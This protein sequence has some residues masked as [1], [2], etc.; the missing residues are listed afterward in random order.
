M[1]E[2]ESCGTWVTKHNFS[3]NL[4][5]GSLTTIQA[6]AAELAE[7]M[8]SDVLFVEDSGH[9]PQADNPEKVASA[10]IGFVKRIEAS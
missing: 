1:N 8:N 2:Q 6:A 9:Y 7:R 10:I 5:V 3:I 4:A